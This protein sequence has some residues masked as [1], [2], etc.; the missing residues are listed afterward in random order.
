MCLNNII[1]IGIDLANYFNGKSSKLSS[2][3]NHESKT[4]PK[5]LFEVF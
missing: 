4:C 2:R 5:R 1:L 3:F